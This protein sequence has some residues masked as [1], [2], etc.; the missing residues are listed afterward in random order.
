MDDYEILHL[1]PGA[2]FAEIQQAYRDLVRVWHPDRFSGD[3]RLQKIA[4][5]KLK[6]INN[7]YLALEKSA[8]ETTPHAASPWPK[9]AAERPQASPPSASSA[10]RQRTPAGLLTLLLIALG[11]FVIYTFF[12]APVRALQ[13]ISADAR[14]IA[15]SNGPSLVDAFEGWNGVLP[16]GLDRLAALYQSPLAPAQRDVAI[17]RVP[18]PPASRA[19]VA[20]SAAAAPDLLYGVGEIPVHNR[21]SEE[22][23]LNLKSTRVRAAERRIAVPSDGEVT[24]GDLGPDLYMVDVSFPGS[25]R[26]PM[27]LGPFVM[28]EIESATAVT[29]DRYEI[30]LK[31]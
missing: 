18:V 22:I 25:Q 20:A 5:E 4:D 6:E 31:P 15:V 10:L 28:V 14:R 27:R 23:L 26:R 16:Q 2:S 19:T 3:P 21:T 13:A 7:A 11:T 30:T 1:K 9:N 12:A 8:Q 24:F 17:S 29:G